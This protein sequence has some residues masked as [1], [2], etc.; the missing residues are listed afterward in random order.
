LQI[1]PVPVSRPIV[2]K[3]GPASRWKIGVAH[4][5]HGAGAGWAF[6]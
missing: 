3:T 1:H 4:N 2:I 5:Y 6:G